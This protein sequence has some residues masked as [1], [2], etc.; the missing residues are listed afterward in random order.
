MSYVKKIKPDI[1][2]EEQHEMG[3][4]IKRVGVYFDGAVP[5]ASIAAGTPVPVIP[6]PVYGWKI[7][8]AATIAVAQKIVVIEDA[9][10]AAGLC[11][12]VEAGDTEALV[13]PNANM[14]ESNEW[15]ELL[16]GGT[17]FVYDNDAGIAKKSVGSVAILKEAPTAAEI[18]A[19]T[20]VVKKVFLTGELG[21]IA[22]A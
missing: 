22:A 14:T 6:D 11:W 20:A 3:G 21:Q 19:G 7:V 12:A 9:I 2:G 17:S 18:A 1:G 4:R 10:S 5:G 13:T 8:A 16:N 15:L